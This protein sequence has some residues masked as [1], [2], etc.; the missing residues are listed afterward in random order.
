MCAAVKMDETKNLVM[1][2]LILVV[3]L[4]LLWLIYTVI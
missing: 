1:T 3:M 2:Y 4:L